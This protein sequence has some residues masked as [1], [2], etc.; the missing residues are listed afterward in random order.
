METEKYLSRGKA[1]ALIGLFSLALLAG[2]ATLGVK[3]PDPIRVS[4]VIEM[5]RNGVPPDGIV[6]Q[7]RDSGSVYRLSAAQLAELHDMGVADPVLDT[8]QQTY[9]DAERRAQ[10]AEG[11]SRDDLWGPE[12]W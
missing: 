8:M 10:S 2:C 9:I 11:W 7:M 1:A 6:K 12:L 4:Q 5:S 3:R